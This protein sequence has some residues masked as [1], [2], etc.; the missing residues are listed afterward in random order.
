MSA[1]LDNVF[2]FRVLYLL[3]TP[4]EQ[5]DAFKLGIIDK[6]GKNL[7]KSKEL[8]TDAERSAYTNL[9]KLVFNMKKILEKVP[10]VGK[11]Q[12]TS[13]A[14]AYWLIKEAHENKTALNETRCLDILTK[15]ISFIEEEIL[16]ERF[17]KEDGVPMG[18]VDAGSIPNVTGH[19]TS[20][21]EPVITRKVPSTPMFRRL[22]KKLEKK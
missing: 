5:T 6:D 12:L 9:H 7:K 20:T 11:S 3:V 2:A 13:L 15:D 8:K 17:L 21:D 18:G 22:K 19:A 4:F 16:V 10:F 14:A 1:F